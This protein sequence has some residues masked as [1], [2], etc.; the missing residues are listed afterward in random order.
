MM[1]AYNFRTMDGD[2]LKRA[3]DIASK[4]NLGIVA[5]KTQGGA[6]EFKEG[7]KSPR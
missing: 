7:E 6:K 3:V 2:K 5:M 1:I 4:A